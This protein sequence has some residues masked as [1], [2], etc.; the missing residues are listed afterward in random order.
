MKSKNQEAGIDSELAIRGQR[1]GIPW[2]I[3]E[4]RRRS[5]TRKE[6]T[7]IPMARSWEATGRGG[8]RA[9]EKF[10]RCFGRDPRL[11]T[12]NST[13]VGRSGEQRMAQR[14]LQPGNSYLRAK[15]YSV[16]GRTL[17]GARMLTNLT[18]QTVLFALSI[19]KVE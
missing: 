2:M 4:A 1:E 16:S 9:G 6:K 7:L 11:E 15:Q 17:D 8:Q 5:A 10:R 14:G 12:Q 19:D 3:G 18:N 13:P